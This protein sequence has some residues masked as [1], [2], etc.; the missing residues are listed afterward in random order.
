MICNEQSKRGSTPNGVGQMRRSAGIRRSTSRQRGITT[1]GFIILA[2]FLGLFSFGVLRLAPIYLNYM[3]VAG[4]V[5]GVKGE[6]EG[7]QATIAAIRKS[8]SRRFEIESVSAIR[9]RDVRVTKI[10]GGTEVSAVYEHSSPFIGNISFMLQF[11][12]TEL[13]RR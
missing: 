2:V 10:D 11:D 9:S 1:L 5:D 13:V 8:I 7:Q 6:F 4:V 12:K 3:K